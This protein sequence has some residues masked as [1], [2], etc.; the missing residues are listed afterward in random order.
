MRWA[1]LFVFAVT[2]FASSAVAQKSE[3]TQPKPRKIPPTIVE[4]QAPVRVSA[5][6]ILPAFTEVWLR[7]AEEAKIKDVKV[8]DQVD[9]VLYRDLYYHEWLLAKAGTPVVASIQSVEEAKRLSRGSNIV[10]AFQGLKLLNDQVLPLMGETTVQG[11]VGTGGKIA[12][13]MVDA[14]GRCSSFLCV[15][16]DIPAIPTALVLG[17]ASKGENLNIK[18][19]TSAPAMVRRDVQIDLSLLPAPESP[20]GATGKV[21]IL[22]GIWSSASSRDLFCNGI[23]LAHLPSK[24]YLAL[25]LKPGY[26]RF[27]I[28]PKR[29]AMEVFV[30]AGTVTKL[31]TDQRHVYELNDRDTSH[32]TMWNGRRDAAQ[33]LM[34]S[35]PVEEHDLIWNTVS[36][37]AGGDC[38][39]AGTIPPLTRPW[40]IHQ[41][42]K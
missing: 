26:Y 41:C 42:E 20:A 2:L 21:I 1:P 7:V 8:G 17:A 24:R 3:V 34:E 39:V 4:M 16:Y 10:I 14:A 38:S 28:E 13:G 40:S 33:L 36:A 11:G 32:N 29:G 9:F 19:N 37:L 5:K 23:P 31:L 22:R 12:G 35:K 18:V 30:N 15:F 6:P 25:D 27:A